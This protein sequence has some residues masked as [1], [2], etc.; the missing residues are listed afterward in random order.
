MPS[1]ETMVR[2]YLNGK[3]SYGMLVRNYG[4]IEV[5][6]EIIRQSPPGSWEE[7]KALAEISDSPIPISFEPTEWKLYVDGVCVDD[8]NKSIGK[9]RGF[10]NRHA[11]P[12]ERKEIAECIDLLQSLIDKLEGLK[13]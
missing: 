7:V 9:L 4:V 8:C 2:D 3:C 1:L 5:N 12:E 11:R 6:E 10:A 13:K